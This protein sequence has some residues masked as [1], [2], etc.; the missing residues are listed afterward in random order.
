[1]FDEY[2]INLLTDPHT[3]QTDRASASWATNGHREQQRSIQPDTHS[4]QRER[5]GERGGGGRGRREE[6]V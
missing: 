6:V 3:L 1:M 5:E 2:L 4:C